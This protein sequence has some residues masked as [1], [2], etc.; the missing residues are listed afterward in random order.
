MCSKIAKEN[1][2]KS[3]PI[4]YVIIDEAPA[5]RP[6]DEK[7]TIFRLMDETEELDYFDVSISEGDPKL[8]GKVYAKDWDLYIVHNK[9]N[10]FYYLYDERKAD[11]VN[12][13]PEDLFEANYNIERD[14]KQ[15]EYV[16]VFYR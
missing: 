11:P 9:V 3:T 1:R 13:W 8:T 2:F 5:F 10:G 12:E 7:L 14:T 16:E 15:G 4:G 6:L